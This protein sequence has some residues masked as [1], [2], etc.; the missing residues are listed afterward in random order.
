MRRSQRFAWLCVT[1]VALSC[2]K[3]EIK[4]IPLYWDAGSSGAV[5][6]HLVSEDTSDLTK[7]QWDSQRFGNVCLTQD[8]F[9]WL[10]E[11]LEKACAVSKVA[12]GA[13][14]KKALRAFFVRSD[15]AIVRVKSKHRGTP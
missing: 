12:C 13:Q 11:T 10:K 5:V 2:S 1:S 8:D 14:E 15:K 6:T 7:E 4:D 9:A 3:L